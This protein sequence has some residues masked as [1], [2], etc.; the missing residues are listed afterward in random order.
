MKTIHYPAADRKWEDVVNQNAIDQYFTMLENWRQGAGSYGRLNLHACWGKADV[1]DKKYQ[2]ETIYIY[3]HLMHFAE[4]L[5]DRFG[6]PKWRV[7]ANAMASQ[8]LYLQTE[9]GGFIHSTSEFEPT[10]NT[11]GC[12]IHFFMPILS[13]CQYYE[14]EHADESIKALIPDAI[15]RHFGFTMQAAWQK[16]NGRFHPLPFA[17]WCG[18][19]NQD[20]VAVA[21]VAWSAK[22]FGTWDRYEKYGKPA[23]DHILSDYYYEKLG[24]FER[25]DGVNFT[26]RIAYY[27]VI[28]DM[29]DLIHKLTGDER[30]PPVI[31]NVESHLLDGLYTGSD[32]YA[33]LSRGAVTDANEK[34]KTKILS[35]DRSSVTVSS[36]PGVILHVEQYLDRNPDLPEGPELRSKL[37]ALRRTL[38][39]YTFADGCAPMAFNPANPVFTVVSMPDVEG[40]P[41]LLLYEL[42]DRLSA[43]K[44]VRL[45]SVIRRYC[46]CAWKQNGCL[47]SFEKG[48]ER[49]YGGYSRYVAG[50]TLGQN[51]RPVLGDFDAPVE[52]DVEEIID[53]GQT[54]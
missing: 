37:D 3:K 50:I 44:P 42:G 19:T 20:L 27:F 53:V 45:P 6:D 29:L 4:L 34:N 47:W 5:Y 11:T 30:L 25:G 21:A 33:H 40:M 52:Y 38:A 43:P 7:R 41:Y 39:A 24:L 1:L 35:W 2:G 26:E 8:I 48:G 36:Y 12:P 54:V 18:V 28:L 23:L 14:W 32:G 16:G 46:G 49:L 17:G 22:L 15:E 13:L 10:F 31:D 9:N 51:E